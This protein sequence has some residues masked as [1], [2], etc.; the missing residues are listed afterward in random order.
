MENV[1]GLLSS[2]K[3]GEGKSL[4][5]C[6]RIPGIPQKKKVIRGAQTG[7]GKVQPPFPLFL[8]PPWAWRPDGYPHWRPGD[9]VVKSE[10][11]GI[12]QS[13][14]RVIILG[15]REDLSSCRKSTGSLEMRRAPFRQTGSCADYRAS[16]AG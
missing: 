15:I 2:D 4:N 7:R 11:Y 5:R 14:H 12:P 8:K 3:G 1:K 13:R 9:F 10:D 16:A 6:W